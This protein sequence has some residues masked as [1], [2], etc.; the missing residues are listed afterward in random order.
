M[1]AVPTAVEMP[2]RA[3]VPPE[4]T[5]V[6][7]AVAAAERAERFACERSGVRSALT[8][9]RALAGHSSA[10]SASS[11][12]VPVVPVRSHPRLLAVS[13]TRS[14]AAARWRWGRARA[15]M[16]GLGWVVLLLAP[17]EVLGALE[18]AADR[19]VDRGVEAEREREVLRVEGEVPQLKRLVEVALRSVSPSVAEVVPLLE[20]AAAI[21][22][23]FSVDEEAVAVARHVRLP[24]RR[25][26]P[27]AAAPR[28][29]ALTP[30]PLA[31]PPAKRLP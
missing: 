2:V 7:A 24:G 8:I 25:A 17:T 10:C 23:A 13:R 21:L 20:A 18:L 1:L 30:P 29:P 14:T 9:S 31:H 11:S 12:P 27:R 19:P 26:L 16:N 4:A 5:A 6:E 22:G 28:P 15:V 3:V